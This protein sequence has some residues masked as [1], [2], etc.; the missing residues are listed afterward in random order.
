MPLKSFMQSENF[1]VKAAAQA[2]V[3]IAVIQTF[4]QRGSLPGPVLLFAA[5]LF[6]LLVWLLPMDTAWRANRYMFVQGII[7]FL[8]C[9]QEF[10][11][12]Y[13]FFVLSMQSMLLF[14]TRPGIVWNGVCLT[15]ALLVNFL[16]H[17]DGDLAPGPRGLAVVV[18][19]I[20]AGI[21]SAGI[22]RVRRDRDEI[23]LLVAQLAETNTLLHE[24]QKKAENLAAVEER[25]RLAR[26]LNNSLGHKLTVAIVQLEG[27]VLQ[28]EKEPGRVAASLNVV[29]DQLKKGLSELRRIAK[30]V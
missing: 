9:L 22:A 15:L 20:L 27:A 1:T 28:L 6:S 24:S 14:S 18:A 16:F 3:L 10:L 2:I 25:N 19:F 5:S 13:L 12:V 8:A 7:A 26:E 21:L 11:F 30:Q 23:R 17:L 4:V 29:H